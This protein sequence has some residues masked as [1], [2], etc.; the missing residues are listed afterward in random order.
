MFFEHVIND[1]NVINLKV[2]FTLLND[3]K[4]YNSIVGNLTKVTI[5]QEGKTGSVRLFLECSVRSIINQAQIVT[6][7]PKPADLDVTQIVF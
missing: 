5:V 1:T 3:I 2:Y 6:A 7:S 4:I